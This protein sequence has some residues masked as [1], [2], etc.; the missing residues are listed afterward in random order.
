MHIHHLTYLVI[1]LPQSRYGRDRKMTTTGHQSLCPK[2]IW[3]SA[4]FNIKFWYF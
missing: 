3:S 1:F 2:S 4:Y